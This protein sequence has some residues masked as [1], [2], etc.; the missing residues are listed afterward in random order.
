MSSGTEMELMIQSISALRGTVIDGFRQAGEERT[1]IAKEVKTIS[2]WR[3]R[4]IGKDEGLSIASGSVKKSKG[5]RDAF[6]VLLGISIT[7]IIAY[8]KSAVL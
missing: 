1:A 3:N 2:E 4:Q 5:W 6:L 8:V 7:V